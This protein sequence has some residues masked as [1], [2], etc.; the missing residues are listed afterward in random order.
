[1]VVL[2]LL[3]LLLFNAYLLF[4]VFVLLPGITGLPPRYEPFV[5]GLLSLGIVLGLAY[6]FNSSAGQFLLRFI[7]GARPA[8]Y[9]EQQRLTPVIERVQTALEEKLGLMP[10]KIHLMVVDDPLPN[11]FA[12]GKCTL[13]V[14][15][16]LYET[17]TDDELAG[18][19]AHELGH[20]HAGDS[21]KLSIALGV[22]LVSLALAFVAGIITTLGG[23][24]GRIRGGE[25]GAMMGLLALMIGFIALFF[26]IFVWLGNAMFRLAMYYQGR[27]Q[28]YRADQFAIKAGFGAGLLGFLDKIKDMEWEGKRTFMRRLTATHPPTLLRIGEIEKAQNE[29]F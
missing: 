4:S 14:S 2:L 13:I 27:R 28:E 17:L 11:A 29:A 23:I 20:L 6:L 24:F 25:A 26:L 21:Q 18:V 8:I 22:S 7:S 9:R 1:M 15:R 5:L 3:L 10:L 19:I 12:L 16:G